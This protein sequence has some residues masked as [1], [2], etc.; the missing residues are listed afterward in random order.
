MLL[1]PVKVPRYLQ[2]AST[3]TLIVLMAASTVV[4]I[5]VLMAALRV[6]LMAALKAVLTL[7]LIAALDL[8]PIRSV[9]F[10]RRRV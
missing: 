2:V 3:P 6:A 5:A 8:K 1:M 10:R 4:S 7:V 9:K